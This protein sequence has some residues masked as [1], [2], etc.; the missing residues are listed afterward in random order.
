MKNLES[1]KIAAA[2]IISALIASSTGYVAS[3]VYTPELTPQ[4]RGYQIEVAAADTATATPGAKQ[5][6]KAPDILPLLKDANVELGKTAAKKCLACHSMDKGGANKVGPNLWAIV[7]KTPASTDGFT[8]S[9]AMQEFGKSGKKWNYEELGKFLY[10]PQKDIKGT[11]MAFAGVKKPDE[12]AALVAYLRSLS[13]NPA[14][15]P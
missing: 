6:E 10:A 9:T 7:G 8:Y 15:L 1:N 3:A 4:K 11:K 2:L 5:E 12:L 14:P 13:D